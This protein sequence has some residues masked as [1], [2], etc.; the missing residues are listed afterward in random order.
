MTDTLK[1]VESRSGAGGLHASTP[2]HFLNF[3]P[4]AFFLISGNVLVFGA[5]S[6]PPL[7][8]F[9]ARRHCPLTGQS[10]SSMGMQY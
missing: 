4:G 5:T 6:P 3:R 1:K 7:F 8:E 9:W 10:V 2:H